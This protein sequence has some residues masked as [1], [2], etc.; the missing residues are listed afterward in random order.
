LDCTLIAQ[1][2]GRCVGGGTRGTRYAL[3][4]PIQPVSLYR[5][6][7]GT[8]CLPATA[9]PAPGGGRGRAARFDHCSTAGGHL[10]PAA[11]AQWVA[12][13]LEGAGG[14]GGLSSRDASRVGGRREAPRPLGPSEAGGTKQDSVFFII[15]ITKHKIRRPPSSS[16]LTP[17]SP[18]V[19]AT[20]FHSPPTPTLILLLCLRIHNLDVKR[21]RGAAAPPHT[22]PQ[23]RA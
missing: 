2:Q 12:L 21:I 6:S 22:H 1:T 3:L 23:H 19:R 11:V 10:P 5:R 8:P 7:S 9:A 16:S 20:P 4:S 14:G 17:H 15:I 13:A 18:A